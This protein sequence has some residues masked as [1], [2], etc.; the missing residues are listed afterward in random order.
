MS[1]L[2]G[3][4]LALFCFASLLVTCMVPAWRAARRDARTIHGV[5]VWAKPLKFM[6]A[7]A[8]FAA[9][10]AVLMP[11]AGA[12]APLTGIAALVIAASA[13]EV[14]YITFQA[15]RGEPSHY[16][17]R[18]TVHATL[19]VLMAGGAIGLS[20]SQAWLA[21]AIAGTNPAWW[22]SVT[23]LGAVTGLAA[24]ALL[25]TIS[26]FLL[27][28]HRAPAGP[29]WHVVGWHRRGDLRPAHFMGVHAQ[30]CIPMFGL[31]AA[32]LP[33]G[34]AHAGFA[35][36]TC[37]YVLAWAALTHIALRRRSATI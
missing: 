21:W 12:S 35:A 31:A 2:T 26:G 7:L 16:N 24:T 17:T 1:L 18:D 4:P 14:A 5:G 34:A 30:Q 13:F 19:T 32:R 20:A 11:A 33:A 9:T 10:T 28:G 23:I 27:G 37:V 22:S 6:A 8:L 36:L 15:S 3:A 25:G 29:G